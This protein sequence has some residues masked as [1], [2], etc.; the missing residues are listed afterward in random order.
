MTRRQF[1]VRLAA[2]V[3]QM[4][5]T[6]C[7]AQSHL[8]ELAMQTDGRASVGAAAQQGRLRARRVT[9]SGTA[10]T[11]LQ[12]LGLDAVRDALLYVPKTYDPARPARLAVM[13]HGAGGNADG[14][15]RLL[16]RWAEDRRV[17]LLAPASRG[18]TWDAIRGEYGEDVA[19]LDR[20]LSQTLARYVVDPAYVAIG[21]FSDG[22]SYALSIGLTNGDLFSHIIAFS[23]CLVAPRSQRGR[24]RVFISHGRRDEVLPID[25]CSRRIVQEIKRAGYDLRFREFDGPHLVAP[26][27]AEEAIDWFV[28]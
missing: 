12:P 13:L 22:A 9:V 8:L 25:A 26:E 6:A 7:D 16:Q 28:P 3:G 5:L 24:P 15:L 14:G 20:A 21:G 17:I 19:F 11:G 23:P 4:L 1:H 2:A 18:R 27:I 10:P